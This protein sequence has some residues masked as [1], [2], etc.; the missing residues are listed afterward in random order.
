M[1]TLQLHIEYLLTRHDC[2]IVPGIGAFIATE[3]EAYI[4]PEKGTISPR[5][6]EFSFNSSVVTDDGLL[7]HSIAR[8]Q[9]LSYE[10]AHR[11]LA[12]ITEKLKSDLHNEGEVSIGMVGRLFMD[13]DGLISFQPRKSRIQADILPDIRLSNTAEDFPSLH[14]SNDRRHAI[15]DNPNSD[16][17]VFRI[18]KKVAHV[19][20]M[21]IAVITIGISIAIPINHDNE[22]KASVI[23][24]PAFLSIPQQSRQ[25]TDTVGNRAK[26]SDPEAIHIEFEP[27]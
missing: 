13:A 9:H 8:R 26:E 20:A 18:H 7:S 12:S 6:R 11:V 5:H 16:Y 14:D 17:Y 24:L 22:Q 27:D 10:E 23:T 21:I 4:D 15:T 1:E 25:T 2:V 3:I 19:A